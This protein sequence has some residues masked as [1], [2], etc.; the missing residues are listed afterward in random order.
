MVAQAASPVGLPLPRSIQPPWACRLSKACGT[1]AKSDSQRS[2]R[3]D[4]MHRRAAGYAAIREARLSVCIPAP[5]TAPQLEADPDVEA[6]QS[7]S[8]AQLPPPIPKRAPSLR[9]SRPAPQL[10]PLAQRQKSGDRLPPPPDGSPRPRKLP[11]PRQPSLGL[12]QAGG[13]AAEVEQVGDV[14]EH[15]RSM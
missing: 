12:L 8:P 1:S 15:G 11:M 13:F 3:S 10:P 9:P 4:R 7:P 2:D 6:E 5:D 14:K